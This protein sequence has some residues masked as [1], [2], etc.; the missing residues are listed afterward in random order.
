MSIAT[1]IQRL[2]TAKANIKSA[3]EEKGV[4]VG[5]GTIDTYA[6]LISLISGGGNVPNTPEMQSGS[7]TVPEDT[8]EGQYISLTLSKAPTNILVWA[9]NNVQETY[10]HLFNA[11]GSMLGFITNDNNQIC[12]YHTTSATTMGIGYRNAKN[13]GIKDVTKDGFTVR[14]Y[15][16]GTYYFRSAT[17]YHWLAWTDEVN[18]ESLYEQGYEDGK[19]SVVD[20]ARYILTRPQFTSLNMFGTS[21][22]TLN[23]DSIRDGGDLLN[24]FNIQTAERK[25]ITVEHLTVNCPALI[26][27]MQQTFFATSYEWWD[28]TLK[29]LTLNIDTQKVTN[30]NYTF[31]GLVALETIDGMPLN[32]SSSTSGTNTCFNND[33]NIKS[34]RVVANSIKTNFVIAKS[35]GLDT[36]TIQSIF[37]GLATV[38]TAQTLTLHNDVKILQ[39]QV[40]SANAK[41]WTVAGGTVVSEEEYYA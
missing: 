4:T 40:D 1:E 32:F 18:I 8:A 35:S 10:T 17:A 22:A 25:N 14:G 31:A 6:N 16:E 12:C 11:Y 33:E 27:N 41:G 7:F 24:M 37:D 9:E 26:N 13:G 28:K 20:F 5:D 30:W 34:F 19:N 29:R 3:I 21:E 15:T 23:L 39:S 36:D 2:K 38:D